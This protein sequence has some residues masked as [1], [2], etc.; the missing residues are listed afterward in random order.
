MG[1][2]FAPAPDKHAGT[3]LNIV[4][5]SSAALALY[6][7]ADAIAPFGILSANDG[8]ERIRRLGTAAALIM[9]AYDVWQRKRKRKSGLFGV[10]VLFLAWTHIAAGALEVLSSFPYLVTESGAAQQYWWLLATLVNLAFYAAIFTL[11][12]LLHREYKKGLT[13]RRRLVVLAAC[14]GGAALVRSGFLYGFLYGGN[15]YEYAIAVIIALETL[16]FAPFYLS[17][18]ALA[19]PEATRPQAEVGLSRGLLFDGDTPELIRPQDFYG[20]HEKICD[21]CVVTF[22]RAVVEKALERFACERVAQLGCINGLLP[23]YALDHKGK[24]IAFYMSFVGATGAGTCIEEVNCLVGTTKFVMFGSSGSLR[25]DI[26]AGKLIVPVEA[27][28][29]EGMSYHYVP[30]SEYIQIRNA[31][32]VADFLEG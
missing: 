15:L 16:F 9:L 3:I 17:A 5:A 29:D 32:R 21:V 7:I 31:D 18:L 27:Y 28:R 10:S 13:D 1:N 2:Q 14:T 11:L 19:R 24:K 4:C 30:P 12:K 26:A 20:V 6:L 22:S 8:G 23:V 25:P